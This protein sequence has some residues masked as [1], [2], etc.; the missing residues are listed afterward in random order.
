MKG[1]HFTGKQLTTKQYTAIILIVPLR[2]LLQYN[3]ALK[4]GIPY[5]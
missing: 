1:S 5:L 3:I 4:R 2:L